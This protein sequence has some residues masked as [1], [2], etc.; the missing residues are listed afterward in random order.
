[1]IN[2]PEVVKQ[3]FERNFEKKKVDSIKGIEKVK[4]RMER[5]RQ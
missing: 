1:M 3:K 5:A 2:D 4:D